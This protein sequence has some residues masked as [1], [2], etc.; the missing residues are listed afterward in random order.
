MNNNRENKFRKFVSM[1]FN[2]TTNMTKEIKKHDAT[3]HQCTECGFVYTD[4]KWAERCEAWCAEHKSHNLDIVSHALPAEHEGVTAITPID[5]ASKR[6]ETGIF[7]GAIGVASAL[8]LALLLYFVLRLD[9]TIG[10]LIE[11]TADKLLYFWSYAL[12]TLGTIA[13]FGVNVPL[14][15]Y[16]VRRFGMPRLWGQSGTGAGAAFGVLASACPMCGSTILAA[17]GIAGGLIAL[18]LDGLEL[19]GLSFVLMALPVAL[20]YRDIKKKEK[21]CTDGVC[22]APRDAS[23]NEKKDHPFLLAAYALII[24][25]F[26][27][28]WNMLASD[29]VMAKFASARTSPI[30]AAGGAQTLYASV[31]AQVLPK[32]GFQSK[33]RLGDSIL[34]LVEKG[35]IDKEKLLTIYGGRGGLPPELKDVLEK[36]SDKPILLTAKNAVYYVNLLWPIGL[37]NYMEGNKNSPLNKNNGADLFGFASTGGWNIGKEKNGGAYFNKFTIVP[38]TSE[39]ETLVLKIAKNSYRPC[40]NNSTFFQDCNHGSALLGLLALGASQGLSEEEL[41]REALAFNSFWFP[42]TYLYNALYFKAVKNTDW[43]DVDASVV[44]GKEYSSAS[45]SYAVKSEV[46]K[47][48]NLIPQQNDGSANCGT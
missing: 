14:L 3:L 11:N 32:D 43:K 46:A 16:R 9:S 27:I 34:K 19:K 2:R 12:L 7:Y 40:C 1:C 42:D 45:G 26:A 44:L 39:Q 38:L 25:F 5:A 28:F 24:V 31:A 20:T 33:I 36:Q 6:D 15:I 17:L 37:S 13:L 48:P 22:P 41:W 23:Y 18:P 47:I 21:E 30:T 8:A 10:M 4:K 35:V 29:P